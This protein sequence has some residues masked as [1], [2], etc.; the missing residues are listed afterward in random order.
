[1][2]NCVLKMYTLDIQIVCIKK[3]KNL[4]LWML[5]TCSEAT[6]LIFNISKYIC[7]FYSNLVYSFF[8]KYVQYSLKSSYIKYNK[9]IY[10]S[11]K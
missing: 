3:K 6:K 11:H 10:V 5:H 1:M 2:N 4:T 7:F 8:I 9:T